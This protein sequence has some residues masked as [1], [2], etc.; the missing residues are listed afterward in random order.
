MILRHVF[1]V[2]PFAE[3]VFAV[4]A[5][6]FVYG[7][8]IEHFIA[9]PLH[10]VYVRINLFVSAC[11]V[12]FAVAAELCPFSRILPLVAFVF[13]F[14]IIAVTA[15]IFAFAVKNL[16]PVENADFIAVGKN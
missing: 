1:P 4:H 8:R 3:H 12:A 2:C 11:K 10:G 14:Q 6:G 15:D 9:V 16:F 7:E 13:I 5:R